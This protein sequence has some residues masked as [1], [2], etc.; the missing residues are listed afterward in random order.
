MMGKYVFTT[1]F[2]KGKP[3]H[4]R[5]LIALCWMKSPKIKATNSGNCIKIDGRI[6]GWIGKLRKKKSQMYWSQYRQQI[7][8]KG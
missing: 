3:S 7:L 5:K 4:P 6:N 2:E 8:M 1:D